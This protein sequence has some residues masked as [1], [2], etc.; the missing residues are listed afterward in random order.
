MSATCPC[1]HFRFFTSANLRERITTALSPV[2]QLFADTV[3]KT[4]EN[5]RALCTGE[6]G[7][8]REGKPLHYKGSA[9]YK[10]IPN[11]TCHGGDI[12]RYGGSG[13]LSNLVGIEDG[14][15]LLPF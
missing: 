7:N 11:F 12:T 8:G 6:K 5:F 10:I 14:Q 3:P 1:L 9:F 4:A 15:T 13:N 2:P